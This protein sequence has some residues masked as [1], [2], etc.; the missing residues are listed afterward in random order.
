M[1]LSGC[2]GIL[3]GQMR[4][5]WKKPGPEEGTEGAGKG[6]GAAWR[7]SQAGLCVQSG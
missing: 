4:E 3:S 2:D 6:E 5:D 7:G 1:G